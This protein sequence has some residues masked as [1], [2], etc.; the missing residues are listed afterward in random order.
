MS[1]RSQTVARLK[2]AR[3]GGAALPDPNP[4]DGTRRS[5]IGDREH[6]TPLKSD[7]AVLAT[8][9]RLLI[10]P[11]LRL[12]RAL[13]EAV[14]C[15]LASVLA[16]VA[17]PLFLKGAVDRLGQ[18]RALAGSTV[19]DLVLFACAAAAPSLLS[20]FRWAAA[21]RISEGLNLEI[22]RQ[23]LQSRLA[24]VA[25]GRLDGATLTSLMERLPFSLQVVFNGLL[26]RLP[27]LALQAAASL[28]ALLIVAPVY[29]TPFAAC[30]LIY[31]VLAELGGRDFDR[32]V[33][34]AHSASLRTASRLGDV[35]R[36]AQRVVFN[37]AVAHELAG[38]NAMQ[39]ERR[40]AAEGL[41]QRMIRTTAFQF[42]GLVATLGATLCFSAY[43]VSRGRLTLGAFVLLQ[44]FIFQLSAPLAGIGP[45]LRQSALALSNLKDAFKLVAEDD[46]RSPSVLPL[47]DEPGVSVEAISFGYDK[48]P[49]LDGVSFKLRS[50]SFVCLV[51]RNGSGKS[52]LA[53]ILGGLLTPASGMVRINGAPVHAVAPE[54][55][56]DLVLYAPQ[57]IGLLHRS[58]AEN[59]LYPPTHLTPAELEA[60][61]GSLQFTGGAQAL[62]LSASV[63]DAGGRLSGGQIQKL[64]L[65]RLKGV[66]V[67]LL[68]LDETTS[69]LDHDARKLALKQ[70]RAAQPDTT[71]VLVTHDPGIAE[72]ADEVLHL[73]GGRLVAQG[74]HRTLIIACASYRALWSGSEAPVGHA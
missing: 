67:P 5:R 47:T 65:T 18:H 17:A 62:D 26:G 30:L 38:L 49:L 7:L 59:G 50:G 43:G 14:A 32:V 28:L 71:L 27:P 64:E 10:S 55:R 13:L 35:I 60:G 74:P 41:A 25:R 57:T 70:L 1:L 56:C 24:E 48:E 66:S 73:E 15:D 40:S 6:P 2:T 3:A 39:L 42:C 8:L 58:L 53:Q 16:G 44:A 36:N 31:G 12:R 51:G 33:R 34:A 54:R 22:S 11:R 21:V 4:A 37:G 63:G 9:G 29:T 20:E 69:A 23:I 52:T 72:L 61:L 46:A 68:L 19:L 45:M